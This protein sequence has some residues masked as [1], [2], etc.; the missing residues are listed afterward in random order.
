MHSIQ[1]SQANASSAGTRLNHEIPSQLSR[2]QESLGELGRRSDALLGRLESVRRKPVPEGVDS[3]RTASGTSPAPAYGIP[4]T[5]LGT[6]LDQMAR[7]VESQIRT[8]NNA[9]DTLE[10][11]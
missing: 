2:L 7:E 8:L 11:A 3:A 6:V 5:P 4:Q 9:I 1:S 10:I